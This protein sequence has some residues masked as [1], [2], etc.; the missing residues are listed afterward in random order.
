MQDY[1]STASCASPM[2]SM[3][4]QAGDLTLAG[5]VASMVDPTEPESVCFDELEIVLAVPLLSPAEKR[6]QSRES[7]IA[8]QLSEESRERC[9]IRQS[10]DRRYRE[11]R[12]SRSWSPEQS[13]R[14]KYASV[15]KGNVITMLADAKARAYEAAAAA[16]AAA[17]TK[18][19]V[20]SRCWCCWQ[21]SAEDEASLEQTPQFSS[22]SSSASDLSSADIF[23]SSRRVARHRLARNSSSY[24]ESET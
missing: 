22:R 5:L 12:Q 4:T 16:A 18:A 15:R 17:A 19:R 1:C 21:D 14:Q 8:S 6:M 23:S 10:P 20:V 13:M 11:Q 24:R 9:G 3:D 2:E 7:S